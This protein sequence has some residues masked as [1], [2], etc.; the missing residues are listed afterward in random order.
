M[1]AISIPFLGAGYFKEEGFRRDSK[2]NTN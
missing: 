2:S 1:S